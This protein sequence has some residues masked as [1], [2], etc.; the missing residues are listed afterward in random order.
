MTSCEGLGVGLKCLIRTRCWVFS[1]LKQKTEGKPGFQP[2]TQTTL[3]PF[4]LQRCTEGRSGDPDQSP[5]NS[6]AATISQKPFTTAPLHA[7]PFHFPSLPCLH[8]Y[9]SLSETFFLW[10]V[11]SKRCCMPQLPLLVAICPL[12]LSGPH[13][14]VLWGSAG[15]CAAILGRLTDPEGPAGGTLHTACPESHPSCFSRSDTDKLTFMHDRSWYFGFLSMVFSS[16]EL[17]QKAGVELHLSASS[18]CEHSPSSQHVS[19][20]VCHLS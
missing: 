16:W 13:H 6:A 1:H 8:S 17:T 18:Q 14:K 12:A 19:T 7:L 4:A 20:S 3:V 15:P 2:E 5:H 9:K 11:I 10:G